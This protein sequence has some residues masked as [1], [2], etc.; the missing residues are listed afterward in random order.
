MAWRL[1][2]APRS[3]TRPFWL[4]SALSRLRRPQLQMPKAVI[5]G[6]LMQYT[7]MPTLGCV[8]ILL[9]PPTWGVDAATVLPAH[10]PDVAV[11]SL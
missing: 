1:C 2:S 10:S 4:L 5:A 7:V 6:V 9:H 3:W 11:H 8:P